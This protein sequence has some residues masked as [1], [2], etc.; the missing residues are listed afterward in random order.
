MQAS[1]IMEQDNTCGRNP[2]YSIAGTQATQQ[3]GAHCEIVNNPAY[4][5]IGKQATQQDGAYYET[6]DHTL[7]S[8]TKEVNTVSRATLAGYCSIKSGMVSLVI[9]ICFTLT[10]CNLSISLYLL[11]GQRGIVMEFAEGSPNATNSSTLTEIGDLQRAVQGI[12]DK[13]WLL[14]HDVNSTHSE[15]RMLTETT[16]SQ[17]GTAVNLLALALETINSSIVEISHAPGMLCMF[18]IHFQLCS[19]LCM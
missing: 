13:L 6:V 9:T 7:P 19:Q 16:E 3:E 10:L 8:V 5:I 14:T 4:S 18:T 2:A 12:N 1:L 11:I 17:F 15:V